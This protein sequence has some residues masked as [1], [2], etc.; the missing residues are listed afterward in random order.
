[1][2]ACGIVDGD[3]RTEKEKSSLR[4]RGILA[5]PV[6]EVEN[7]YYSDAVMRVVGARQAETM[8]ETA[9]TLISQ[10]R[11]A[12]LKAIADHDAPQRLAEAVALAVLRRRV[13]EELPTTVDKAATTVTVSFPSPYP[14][15]LSRIIALL[16]ADDLDGLIR[17]VPI[18]DTA[19]RGQVARSLRFL[20]VADYEACAHARIRADAALAAE[21]RKLMGPMPE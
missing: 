6:S 4:A 10:A 1:L 3:G 12:M 13:L 5:L 19:L 18:R 16:D 7:L 15:I 8:D 14:A 2:N 11:T 9:D 20:N 21:V 17:L